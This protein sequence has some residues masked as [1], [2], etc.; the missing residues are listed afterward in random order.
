[1]YST[2]GPAVAVADINGDGLDDLFF[3]GAK[4]QPSVLYTQNSNGT[5]SEIKNP[6]IAADSLSE[7]VDALFLDADNDGDKDLYVVSGGNEYF[8]TMPPLLDRLYINDGKGNFSKSPTLPL[9]YE[10]KSCVSSGDMDGDGDIDLFVGSQTNA[11]DYGTI[12]KSFLLINDGKGNFTNA[13]KEWSTTLEN[14]GMVSDAQFADLDKDNKVDLV[15]C[16]EWMQPTIF[17]NK[18]NKLVHLEMALPTGMYRTIKVV[19]MDND[20]LQ[21]IIVGNY[22]LNSKL[23]ATTKF[24]LKLDIADLDNNGGKDQILSIAKDGEYFTFLG[25]EYLEKQLPYLKKEYLSYTKNI[26]SFLADTLGSYWLKNTNGTNFI[27][28][29]LP[30]EMQ[31]STLNDFYYYNT[32]LYTASNFYGVLPYEGRYDAA[33]F[34]SYNYNNEFTPNNYWQSAIQ[35]EGRKIVPI[36]IANKDCIILLRNNDSPLF[37]QLNK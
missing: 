3:G 16:G 6:L 23:A 8:D 19:D 10:N 12:P 31:W 20:G 15:I 34:A 35:G 37:F 36:N 18:N 28:Q 13:T 32:T 29:P 1:M 33:T 17:F 9:L 5:F 7:D 11:K 4:T 25:K 22:G 2:Q 21:D 24:P 27:M 14:I 26:K 30:I